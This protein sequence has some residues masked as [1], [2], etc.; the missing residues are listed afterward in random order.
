MTSPATVQSDTE[1]LLLVTSVML[2]GFHGPNFLLE[3]GQNTL[4]C[5]VTVGLS[6]IYRMSRQTLL[7]TILPPQ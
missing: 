3:V 2:R 4:M 1:V 6:L 7:K 5:T